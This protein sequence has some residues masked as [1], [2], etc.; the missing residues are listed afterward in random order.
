MNRKKNYNP[1][2]IF[3][4]TFL[5]VFPRSEFSFC[6]NECRIEKIIADEMEIAT[7][8]ACKKTSPTTSN[9]KRIFNLE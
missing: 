7:K 5:L 3:L 6:S 1:D 9:D 4:I 2:V 8:K